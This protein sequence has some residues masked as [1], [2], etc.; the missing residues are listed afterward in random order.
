MDEH[1]LEYIVAAI[2]T[3]AALGSSAPRSAATTVERFR[4][5][6]GYLRETGGLAPA[7]TLPH[8]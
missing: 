8:D 7:R 2:L 5:V 3:A 1:E 6:I 4:E